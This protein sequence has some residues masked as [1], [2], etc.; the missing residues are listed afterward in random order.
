[1]ADR[2]DYTDEPPRP[3]R[4]EEDYDRPR[5]PVDEAVRM[6]REDLRT[7]AWAQK[8][9][10][11]CI[12]GNLGTA[13]LRFALGSL[14]PELQSLSVLG[15]VVYYLAVCLTATACVFMMA[16]KVYGTGAGV[17]LGLLTLIPAVGL[18]VLLIVNAKATTIIKQNGIRVGLLGANMSDLP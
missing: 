7:V 13:P 17:V 9:I 5:R 10:I 15:L 8:I 3:R 1:M 16:V 2:E 12:L 11:L 18:I 4:R 14:P 6:S